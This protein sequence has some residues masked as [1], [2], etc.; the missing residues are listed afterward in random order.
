MKKII[1]VF[2][3]FIFLFCFCSD[4]SFAENFYI[5]DYQ[6]LMTVK[7]N[8]TVNI[9][10]FIRTYFTNQSHGIYRTIPLKYTITRDD[11]SKQRVISKIN[12]IKSTEN[13]SVQREGGYCKIKLGNPQQSII[14]GQDYRIIYEYSFPADKLSK[15]DEFY[16][17]IIG[18]E[19]D[20]DIHKVSF[21]IKMP[22]EFDQNQIGFSIGGA[23]SSGYNPDDLTYSVNGNIITGTVNRKLN[24]REGLTIRITLP[25]GYFTQSETGTNFLIP[26]FVMAALTLLAFL[27]WFFFGKDDP[28]VPVVNFYPPKNT[29]SAEA[30]VEFS[31]TS[32][33][34]EIVS[35]I[36]CLASKG[37]IEIEITGNTSPLDANFKLTKL[38]DYDGNNPEESDMMKALFNG[39]NYTD[40]ANLALSR[41]FYQECI[42]M[43]K[44]LKKRVRAQIFEKTVNFPNVSLFLISICGILGVM[45]YALELGGLFSEDILSRPELLGSLA[46]LLFVF[47]ISIIKKAVIG[48]V[49][50]VIFFLMMQPVLGNPIGT[51]IDTVSLSSDNLIIFLTGVVCL[52]ISVIC[53]MNLEKRNKYGRNVLGEL[54]GLKKFLEVARKDEIEKLVSESPQ[55]CYDI[56]PYAYVLGVSDKWIK[57]FENIMKEP[58]NWYKGNIH[59]T[60]GHFTSSFK[61]VSIPSRTNGGI[62]SGH[63]GRGGRSGGGHG[64]GGGGSW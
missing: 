58:P 49:V 37:Y 4:K 62:S 40:R 47:T 24:P 23:G 15:N 28:V 55:Y 52:I 16:F 36:V 5:T 8:R 7:E 31:G 41:T 57:N 39:A 19:W 30:G 56:L 51:I 10:E 11:G 53:F 18:N 1:R 6:V 50:S 20:T 54:Q 26:V 42:K 33:D 21:K 3:S 60:F 25:E 43:K 34:K 35:L 12:N 14:G 44:N 59:H 46:V 9:L 13:F 45:I 17:N 2:I 64:G 29:N 63:G 38:K 27:V 22:K 32:A 61:S 48:I